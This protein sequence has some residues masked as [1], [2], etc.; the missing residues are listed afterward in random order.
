MSYLNFRN[1]FL[2]GLLVLAHHITVK[3]LT[4][5][6]Y[7]PHKI[8]EVSGFRACIVVASWNAPAELKQIYVRHFCTQGEQ[9][10]NSIKN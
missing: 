9:C 4:S 3:F 1:Y 10:H 2:F 8:S 7:G 5:S 6:N